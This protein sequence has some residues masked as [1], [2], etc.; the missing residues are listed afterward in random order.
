MGKP[1]VRYTD[2]P[3]DSS[4][5]LLVTVEDGKNTA[6]FQPEEAVT[7]YRSLAD[8]LGEYGLIERGVSGST[9]A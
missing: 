1:Q 3:E 9:A 5:L 7:I 8:V 4:K 2:R 6:I